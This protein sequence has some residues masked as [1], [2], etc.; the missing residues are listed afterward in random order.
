[1][2]FSPRADGQTDGGWPTRLA[3]IAGSTLEQE[4][5]GPRASSTLAGSPPHGPCPPDADQ[6]RR[7][8]FAS[9]TARPADRQVIDSEP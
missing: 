4:G 1:M 2:S 3:I 6:R 8:P 7:P 9:G 5:R